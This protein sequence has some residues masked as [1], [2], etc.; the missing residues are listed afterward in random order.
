MEL[1]W[2]TRSVQWMVI[3]PAIAATW[4]QFRNQKNRSHRPSVVAQYVR[5]LLG[6]SWQVNGDSISFDWNGQIVNGQHRLM[7][8]VQAAQVRNVTMEIVVVTGLDPSVR[9]SVDIHAKRNMVNAFEGAGQS[10]YLGEGGSVAKNTAAGMWQRM[11]HGIS[12]VKGRDTRHELLSFA[13]DYP[14]GGLFALEHFGKFPRKSNIC[15]A[16]VIAALARAYYHYSDDVSLG[17]LSRFAEVLATG[18][19]Q[20][21]VER[22]IIVLREWLKD[23]GGRNSNASHEIYGKTARVIQAF[24]SGEMLSKIYLPSEEPFPLPRRMSGGS[25]PIPDRMALDYGRDATGGS[26]T[27]SMVARAVAPSH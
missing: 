7:A 10:Q 20:S 18:L 13:N 3:T 14:E 8:L 22:T 12:S 27:H 5:D 6:G 15:T 21:P 17:R 9:P 16:P 2:R 23:S 24:M 4:L 26:G 1:N 19:Q 25:A 11:K